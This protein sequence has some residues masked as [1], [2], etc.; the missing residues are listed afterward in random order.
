[1]SDTLG[2]RLRKHR[3]QRQIALS[4]IVEETKISPALLNALE[5]DDVSR[6]PKG[7]FRRAFVRSYARAIGLD[8][9]AVLREFLA[10]HPDPTPDC[11]GT[12]SS[13]DANAPA[14]PG[15]VHTQLGR[16]APMN[17]LRDSSVP[18]PRQAF[19]VDMFAAASLCTRVVTCTTIANL[20]PL[21]DQMIALLAARG[22]MV[23]AP[24]APRL[25]PA[26][27]AGY[28]QNIVSR[29]GVNLDADNATA[30]AFRSG[31]M[32][33]VAGGASSNGA[34]AT[35]AVSADG[36]VGVLAIEL[37][38]GRERERLVQAAAIMWAA[39]LAPVLSTVIPAERR[40][41]ACG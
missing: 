18:A 25:V 27:A 33:I 35:P 13:G 20:E 14:D 9:D 3:E 11:T 16:L 7:I 36:P 40:T 19:E 41:R 4:A 38:G 12:E 6:W 22:V 29:L 30:A 26:A 1:M 8:S 2:E 31:E 23:W 21:L 17:G 32:K 34:V 28:D 10:V 15:A 24:V 37:A 5:R 39:Q